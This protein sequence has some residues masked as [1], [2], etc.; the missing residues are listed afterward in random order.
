MVPVTELF[1]SIKWFIQNATDFVLIGDQNLDGKRVLRLTGQIP[2][3]GR[4]HFYGYSIKEGQI[5]Y[6]IDAETFLVSRA[7]VDVTSKE[8][9][10]TQ[11]GDELVTTLKI[12]ATINISDYGKQVSIHE[13][14]NPD[15]DDHGDEATTA[16]TMTLDQP[17]KGILDS[18]LDVDYYRF[19][20]QANRGYEIDIVFE[21]QFT[22]LPNISLYGSDGVRIIGSGAGGGVDSGLY[23]N[24]VSPKSGTC[25]LAL[26]S[27]GG[28]TG[29]YTATISAVVSSEDDHGNQAGE[30]TQLSVGEIINGTIDPWSDSD[31]FKFLAEE[32][33][34]YLIRVE[35]VEH[36]PI[37]D[38]GFRLNIYESDG[39]TNAYVN[40]GTP[41]Y[42]SKYKGGLNQSV[43]QWT[44]RTK[45][46][47]YITVRSIEDTKAYILNIEPVVIVDDDHNRYYARFLCNSDF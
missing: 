35:R 34:T 17:V 4:D 13:P 26:I 38:N 18:W 41:K 36:K 37:N 10:F 43:L 39:V 27:Y 23:K 33:H 1:R 42:T 14:Q 12:K 8:T 7:T 28:A 32:D 44:A 30:A 21:S 29:A 46:E 31:Y 19:E 47:Y 45:G 16:T 3:Q 15:R 11:S 6:W 24:W 40:G 22:S 2:Q 25:Y 20:A 5:E 9:G